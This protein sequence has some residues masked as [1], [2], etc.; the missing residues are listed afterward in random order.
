R[1]VLPD[2]AAKN[3]CY[4]ESSCWIGHAH[5]RTGVALRGPRQPS[6]QKWVSIQGRDYGVEGRAD[7]SARVAVLYLGAAR[8]QHVR[9]EGRLGK[10]LRQGLQYTADLE[11]TAQRQDL[12][13]HP[14]L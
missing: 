2:V 6:L 13:H 7:I 11:A 12:D 5:G 14:Q 1:G 4:V 9:Q 8:A 10:G 3:V